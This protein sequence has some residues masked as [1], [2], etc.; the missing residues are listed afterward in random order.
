MTLILHELTLAQIAQT[1]V[2]RPVMDEDP[3]SPV[4]RAPDPIVLDRDG[5]PVGQTEN[6]EQYSRA[7]KFG[8]S[9]RIFTGGFTIGSGPGRTFEQ[10][11]SQGRIFNLPWPAKIALMAA[12]SVV[13]VFGLALMIGLLVVRLFFGFVRMLWPF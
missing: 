7:E 13:I 2:L 8:S 1:A 5:N 4:H 12:V 3:Q 6:S 9:T 10:V 11:F